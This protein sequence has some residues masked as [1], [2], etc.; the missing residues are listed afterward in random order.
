MKYVVANNLANGPLRLTQLKIT[1]TAHKGAYDGMSQQL[2][3]GYFQ[4]TFKHIRNTFRCV[5]V[6]HKQFRLTLSIANLSVSLIINSSKTARSADVLDMM[7]HNCIILHWTQRKYY[8]LIYVSISMMMMLCGIEVSIVV[9][10]ITMPW[11]FSSWPFNL[12]RF[13]CSEFINL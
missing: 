4:Y 5:P 12:W 11:F 8:K 2:N 13:K 9:C 10:C 3:V 6:C 1:N 7:C